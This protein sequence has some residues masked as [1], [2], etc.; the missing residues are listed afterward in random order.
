MKKSKLLLILIL[1]LVIISCSKESFSLSSSLLYRNISLT[2][3]GRREEAVL[4]L[5]LSSAS[6]DETYTFLLVSPD[7][8]LRWEGSLTLSGSFYTS[9][10]LGITEGARFE[11][12]EYRL[13]IYSS[14]GSELDRTISLQKEEGDYSFSNASSKDD[15]VI[16][17]YDREGFEI[18]AD[19]E[20]DWAL[21]R[22][23]DRYSNSITLRTEFNV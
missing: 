13:Y 19:E 2:E 8:D 23:S 6:G 3:E 22:Y 17:Y 16:T 12:G 10:T 4:K 5:S 20:A 18:N 14:S 15:A 9:D 21:I 7:G 1:S 11:E